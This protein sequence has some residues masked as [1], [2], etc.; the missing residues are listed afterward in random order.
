MKIFNLLLATAL[1]TGTLYAKKEKMLIDTNS[2]KNSVKMTNIRNGIVYNEKVYIL[3]DMQKTASASTLTQYAFSDGRTF[4]SKSEIMIKFNKDT[5]VN[6]NEI[7]QTYHLEFIRKM[8]SGDYLFKNSANTTLETIN[9]IL[10]DKSS[11]IE[12][13]SPNVIFN[14]KPL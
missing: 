11:D 3:K 10:N 8:N 7:E 4:N 5:N 6:I 9:S 12:R 13:I 2:I 1:L 14:M